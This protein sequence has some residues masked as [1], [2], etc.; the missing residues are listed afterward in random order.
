MKK[1]LMIST[2]ILLGIITFSL[3][4]DEINDLKYFMFSKKDKNYRWE[5]NNIIN[6]INK[7]EHKDIKRNDI[8]IKVYKDIQV[9]IVPFQGKVTLFAIQEKTSPY[10][11]YL[12]SDTDGKVNKLKEFNTS[13]VDQGIRLDNIISNPI[14]VE[15]NIQQE[16]N[17]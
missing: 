3:S 12:I 13:K 8:N 10:E 5:I 1:L 17:N 11:F 14:F 15:L 9:N 2:T 4:S 6:Y 7:T 16:T